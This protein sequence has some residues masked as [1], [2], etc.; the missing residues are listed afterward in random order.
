MLQALITAKNLKETIKEEESK[1][2]NEFK[3]KL[4]EKF[5]EDER[6]EQLNSQKRRLKELEYKK[7]IEK[8]W[9]EKR[10]QYQ[11]QKE[12]EL[13]ELQRQKL[14]ETY[15]RE[16]IEK[17]KLRLIKE[18]EEILK[19]FFKKGYDKSVNSLKTNHYN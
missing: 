6:L 7:E 14:E 10:I 8:Q 5:K 12:L 18:H 15:K 13:Q 11:Q 17:E 9:Q 19:N 3:R 4:I 2:E 1:A 16:I